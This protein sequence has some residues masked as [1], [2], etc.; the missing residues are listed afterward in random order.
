M[1]NYLTVRDLAVK[2]QLSEQTIYRFVLITTGRS[3]INFI[4]EFKGL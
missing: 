2:V 1:E 4:S 3:Q